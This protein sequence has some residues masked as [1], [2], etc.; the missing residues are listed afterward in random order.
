ME[1]GSRV[2]PGIK[3]LPEH[4]RKTFRNDFIHFVIKQVANS[5]SPW[6]NPDVPSLQATYQLIYPIFPAR[7]QHGD[8][9]HHPVG[10]PL[11]V[12]AFRG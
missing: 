6:T 9:A 1:N 10:C 7:I 11:F 3:D 12:I 2:Y 8:A 5:E 4:I